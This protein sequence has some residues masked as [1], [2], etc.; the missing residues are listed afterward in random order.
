MKIGL[1]IE[2][3]AALALAALFSLRPNPLAALTIVPA[4]SWLLLALPGLLLMRRR[5]R[6]YAVMFL[7]AWGLFIFLHVEEPVSLV[8]N[9]VSPLTLQKP[10]DTYRFITMNC[11]GGQSAALDELRPL[12]PDVVF[13][14][15]S[16]GQAA[17]EEITRQ[18]FGAA[19]SFVYNPDTCIL[20]KGHV[21]EV[22]RGPKALFYTQARAAIPNLGV[23]NLVSLRLFTGSV[24]LDLWNPSCWRVHHEHRLRQIEQIRQ[25]TASV[26][27]A[28]SLVIA[29]D[30]NAPQDDK[31]YSYLPKTLRD[32]FKGTGR[33]LGNTILNDIPVLRIDQIW[34]SHD[35]LA[36]QTF[37]LKSKV[38]DHRLVITDVAKKLNTQP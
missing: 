38:A 14:Q 19:G 12:D 21:E 8:R 13:L 30:F 11:G 16:P 34:V 31:V 17:V 29:G 10:P 20:A 36:R 37:A 28:D 5:N 27:R 15:E 22:T 26:T 33:G 32:A 24:G 35:F 23:V 3:I 4:W 18:L 9:L 2:T 7:C 25:I 1:L 6:A